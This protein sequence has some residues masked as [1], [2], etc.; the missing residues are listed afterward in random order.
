MT[1]S[2]PRLAQPPRRGELLRRALRKG[3]RGHR[4]RNPATHPAHRDGTSCIRRSLLQAD[5]LPRFVGIRRWPGTD[6]AL[7]LPD[8]DGAAI[9]AV[10]SSTLGATHMRFSRTLRTL[11]LVLGVSVLALSLAG[12]AEA[13]KRPPGTG[14]TNTNMYS[15]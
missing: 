13:G 6:L 8:G 9:G 4:S 11:A 5:V 12:G 2:R 14:F 3:S 1:H 10:T 7:L 15:S